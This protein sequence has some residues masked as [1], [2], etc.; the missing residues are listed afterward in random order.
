VTKPTPD[1]VDQL[2]EAAA[3]AREVLGELRSELRE[4]RKV[5]REISAER[6]AAIE[7]VADEHIREH[8]EP[9]F[10]RMT[11]KLTDAQRRIEARILRSIERYAN[12]SLY[13]N[14]QGHGTTILEELRDKIR[15]YDAELDLRRSALDGKLPG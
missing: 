2:N 12:L 14:E 8:L 3:A 11:T 15:D 10:S 9:L 5:T 13:G 4:A 7:A 6:H 1:F